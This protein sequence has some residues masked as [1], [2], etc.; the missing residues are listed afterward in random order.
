[1]PK[2]KPVNIGRKTVASPESLVGNMREAQQIAELSARFD[3]QLALLNAPKVYQ[4]L[5]AFMNEP[6]TLAGKLRSGAAD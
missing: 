3:R 5:S 2:A 1:M 4:A 6:V